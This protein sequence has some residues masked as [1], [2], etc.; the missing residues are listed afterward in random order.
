MKSARYGESTQSTHLHH[1]H[2]QSHH[3][4][5]SRVAKADTIEAED[6]GEDGREL[7]KQKCEIRNRTKREHRIL[8]PWKMAFDIYSK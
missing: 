7:R 8:T 5:G 6:F 3:F 4:A 2:V 1:Q